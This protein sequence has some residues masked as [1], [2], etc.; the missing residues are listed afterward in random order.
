MS[1]TQP[2][3]DDIDESSV[4]AMSID[5]DDRFE[6]VFDDRCADVGDEIEEHLVVNGNRSSKRDVVG[7]VSSPDGRCKEDRGVL[8]NLDRALDDRG[9]EVRIGPDGQMETVLF[10]TSDGNYGDGS[11]RIRDFVD[12]PGGDCGPIGGPG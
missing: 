10:G 9:H 8:H 7:G 1:R 2:G 4:P 3:R 6:P 11:L 12:L 5:D